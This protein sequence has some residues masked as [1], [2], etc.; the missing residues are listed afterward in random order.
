MQYVVQ[1]WHEVVSL[2]SMYWYLVSYD[3]YSISYVVVMHVEHKI[4]KT[5]YKSQADVSPLDIKQRKVRKC[6]IYLADFTWEYKP[7]FTGL[8][9]WQSPFLYSVLAAVL[10]IAPA[11]LSFSLSLFVSIQH[12]YSLSS[13]QVWECFSWCMG[14]RHYCLPFLRMKLPTMRY[15]RSHRRQLRKI[16]VE[17]LKR[18]L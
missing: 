17:L 15:W 8:S 9:P 14:F 4:F 11:F 1:V 7:S 12:Q 10:S 5:V 2:C 13:C 16:F 18:S 3:A 6:F